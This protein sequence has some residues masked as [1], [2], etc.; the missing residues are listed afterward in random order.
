MKA[1]ARSER[2]QIL[3]PGLLA[4]PMI[5]LFVVLIFEVARLS[6][7]KIRHQFA[8]DAG[9][10]LEMNQ[11][12]DLLNRMSYVNGVFP[13]RIFQE[14]YSGS[15]DQFYS[16]GLFPGFPGAVDPDQRE[17]GIQFGPGRAYANVDDP[18]L[19]FGILHMHLPG[20]PAVSMNQAEQEAVGYISVY[21]WLGDVAASQKL[22]F[23]RA[24]QQEHTLLRKSLW[25]NLQGENGEA[26]QSDCPGGP[27]SCGTEPAQDFGNITVRMHFAHGFKHCPV[28]VTIQGQNYSG[29]L[30]GAFGFNG[31]GLFQLA[32]VP[33][34]D[35][36]TLENGYV[37]KQHWI[38]PK[39][40]F[41][42][43]FALEEPYVRARVSSAGGYIWPKTT[44][45]YFTKLYP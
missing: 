12:T 10:S 38:P 25:L 16:A 29:E 30:Q 19:D 1:R 23:D 37:V 34:D 40:Y 22:L 27:S 45:K 13:E 28:I 20:T 5:F 33:K 31:T 32:T 7:E 15:W 21:Q 2:G 39:N 42:Y 14:I 4:F 3:M 6:R 24:T 11:Y 44:P 36:R 8:L 43:D 9:A 17:W 35:L 41:G 26:S 18:P